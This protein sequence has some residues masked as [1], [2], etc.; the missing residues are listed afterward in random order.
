MTVVSETTSKAKQEKRVESKASETPS[1]TE[2][3]EKEEKHE[4]HEK[5][6]KHEKHEKGE[7]EKHEKHEK[8]E[9]GVKGSIIAGLLLIVL[10]VIVYLVRVYNVSYLWWPLTFI[11]I[12]IAIIIYALIATSARRRN[13][14]PPP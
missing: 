6:E 13:P 5:Q 12:G 11:I 1:R 14:Q 7:F 2:R 9:V 8:R 4:K 3:D 10:G